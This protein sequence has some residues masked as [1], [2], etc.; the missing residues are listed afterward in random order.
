MYD[1]SINDPEGFWAEMAE[2]FHWFK[3]WDKVR[4]STTT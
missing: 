4:A 2:Q 3:K 1:R